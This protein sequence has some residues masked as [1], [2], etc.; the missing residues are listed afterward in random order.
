MKYQI[1]KLEANN[2]DVFEVG[3]L[4]PRSYFIPYSDRKLLEKQS[5]LTERFRATTGGSGIMRSFPVFL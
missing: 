3:K 1:K 5:V 4:R 2:F